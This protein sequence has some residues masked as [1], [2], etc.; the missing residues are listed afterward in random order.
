[1]QARGFGYEVV[2]TD[3]LASLHQAKMSGRYLQLGKSRN[4][5]EEQI[6]RQR[7]VQDGSMPVARHAVEDNA[8]DRNAR[9]EGHEPVNKRSDGLGLAAGVD[10]EDD[11]QLQ[12]GG[13]VG[14]RAGSAGCAIEQSHD[15][16]DE[17]EVRPSRHLGE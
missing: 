14:G 3:H 9:P 10:N 13:E 17:D 15:A 7:I 6:G 11:G 1:M 4:R 16:F 12:P 8:G 5:T 2:E